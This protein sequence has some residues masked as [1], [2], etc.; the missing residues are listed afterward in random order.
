MIFLIKYESLTVFNNLLKDSWHN[1]Q[2]KNR[3]VILGLVSWA[4]KTD[5]IRLDF[6]RDTEYTFK[7]KDL[8]QIKREIINWVYLKNNQSFYQANQFVLVKSIRIKRSD[9]IMQ[10]WDEESTHT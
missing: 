3:S 6:Y 10:Q 8:L 1:I 5:V 2:N 7:F 4:L 9:G